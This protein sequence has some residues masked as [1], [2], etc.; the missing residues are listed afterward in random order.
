M[1]VDCGAECAIPGDYPGAYRGVLVSNSAPSTNGKASK[2][3]QA[4]APAAA[5]ATTQADLDKLAEMQREKTAELS[6]LIEQISKSIEKSGAVAAVA[7]AKE[8]DVEQDAIGRRYAV[9]RD[10]ADRNLRVTRLP[11]GD[12]AY[13]IPGDVLRTANGALGSHYAFVERGTRTKSPFIE[14]A[15]SSD[16]Q[17]E[18]AVTYAARRWA[19]EDVV[20]HAE[21]K[22]E[23]RVIEHAVRAGLNIVNDDPRVKS[24]VADEKARQEKTRGPETHKREQ[25]PII[26]RVGR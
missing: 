4:Q 20:I 8:V 18:A 19:G 9:E 11:S 26:E 16:R 5:P 21:G 13:S 22:D 24:L 23:R 17:I 7:P 2:N 10:I 1:A 6:R 12:V 14:I 25:A 3:G 15:G